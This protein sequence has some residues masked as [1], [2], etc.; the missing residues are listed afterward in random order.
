M[1]R[2]VDTTDMLIITPERVSSLGSVRLVTL[3][4]TSPKVA[5]LSAPAHQPLHIQPM[6]QS[7]TSTQ[8]AKS[9]VNP[10]T[11]PTTLPVSAYWTASP[12]THTLMSQAPVPV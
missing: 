7:D 2:A 1:P 11:L 5:Y 10:L 9:L 8:S 6:L 12:T 3:L 4:T